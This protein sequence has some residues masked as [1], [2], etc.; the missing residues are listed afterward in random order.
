MSEFLF[1]LKKNYLFIRILLFG[2]EKWRWSKHES[3]V[4]DRKTA[5]L[6]FVP[7]KSS[8]WYGL[9]NFEYMFFSDVVAQLIAKKIPCLTEVTI[10]QRL[11]CDNA[12]NQFR[13]N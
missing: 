3:Q 12:D 7:T 4:V 13:S 2:I 11:D 8:S 10:I 5:M 9:S 1:L 6:N